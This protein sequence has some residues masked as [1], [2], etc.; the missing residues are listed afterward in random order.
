VKLKSMMAATR[1]KTSAPRLYVSRRCKST[2]QTLP[3]LPRDDTRIE[4]VDTSANDHA[5]DALRYLVNSETK[6]VGQTTHVGL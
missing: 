6:Y 1:D 3:M 4:D 5:A 2:I